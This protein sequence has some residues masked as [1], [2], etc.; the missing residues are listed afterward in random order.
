MKITIGQIKEGANAVLSKVESIQAIRI[1]SLE[2]HGQPTP[3]SETLAVNSDLGVAAQQADDLK[4]VEVRVQYTTT[5][6]SQ[7]EP[8]HEAWAVTLTVAGAWTLID[9]PQFTPLE[10]WS[11]AVLYGVLSVHPYAREIIQSSVSRMGYPPYLL[12]I[13]R[14]PAEMPDNAEVDAP[15]DNWVF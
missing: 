9:A 4:S 1:I 11:F 10:L 8:T 13:F 12:E 6:T 5:A 14:S 15:V 3:D 7:D 2:C